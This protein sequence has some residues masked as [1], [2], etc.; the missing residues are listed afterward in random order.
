MHSYMY[1]LF[2]SKKYFYP[3]QIFLVAGYPLLLVDKREINS[4]FCSDIE[5]LVYRFTTF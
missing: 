5:I 3:A 2:K 1:Q 4:N